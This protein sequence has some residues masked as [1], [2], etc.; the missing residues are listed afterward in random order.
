MY[1]YK[2]PRSTVRAPT[3]LRRA[4]ASKRPESR[5]HL[6]L[7]LHTSYVGLTII[8]RNISP[9]GEIQGVL[10]NSLMFVNYRC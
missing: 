8:N 3:R 1:V 10:F 6:R 2:S 5:L 7:P 4:R 9:E